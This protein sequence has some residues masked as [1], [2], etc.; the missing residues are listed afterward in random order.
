M[1]VKTLQNGS[2]AAN[3]QTI[4]SFGV[5][6]VFELGQKGLTTTNLSRMVELKLAEFL[7]KCASESIGVAIETEGTQTDFVEDSKST[8]EISVPEAYPFE[9]ITN[10]EELALHAIDAYDID[11]DTGLSVKKMKAALKAAI[12]TEGTAEA[13]SDNSEEIINE[14][15]IE[16]EQNE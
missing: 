4:I 15:A 5:G 2:F 1:K 11:L 10:K 6:D 3:P 16:G 12:E 14:I 9:K 8:E 7:S 13:P